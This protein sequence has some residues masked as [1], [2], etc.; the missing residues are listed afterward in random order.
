VLDILFARP[1]HLYRPVDLFGDFDCLGDTV[2]FQSPTKTAAQLMIVDLDLFTRQ[3]GH[4]GGRVLGTA[5]DLIANPDRAIVGPDMDGTVHRLHCG[6]CQKRNLINRFDFL[7]GAGDRLGDIALLAR[8][9][10]GSL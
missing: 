2:H 5:D 9:D 7:R 1:H 6:M 10:A 8:D 3:A 4:L